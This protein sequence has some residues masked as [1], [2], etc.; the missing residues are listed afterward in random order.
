MLGI[1]PRRGRRRTP[2]QV[3]LN[4]L[5]ERTRPAI[6]E[7][8]KLSLAAA[9]FGA[10]IWGL[11]HAQSQQFRL[12]EYQQS[13]SFKLIDAPPGVAGLIQQELAEFDGRDWIK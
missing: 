11:D 7:L 13:V 1:R 9:A 8:F 6:T 3:A 4:N 2:S 12:P 5:L 10:A